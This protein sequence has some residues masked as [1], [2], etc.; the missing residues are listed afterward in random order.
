[1]TEILCVTHKYPPHIGGMERQSYELIK[2]LEKYYTV[3]KIA[4]EDN[5]NKL[6]WFQS[7]KSKI[8]QKLKEHPGIKLIHLNDGS[9]GAACLWL[10]KYTHVPVL[11]TCHGLDITFPLDLYQHKIISRLTAYD[12]AI[13]VSDSTRQECL[14]RGFREESTFTVRNGVDH[15]IADRAFDARI[16]DKLKEKQGV[17]VAGKNVLVT[18]GRSVKR[19]GFSWF[20]KNVMPLL[21]EN[22]VFLMIGS[23]KQEMPVAEKVLSSLSSTMHNKIQL[24]LGVES[25]SQDILEQLALHPN[26]HHL[27]NVPYTDLLDLTAMSDLFVMPNI[28]V[29]GDIEG[30]GLVALEA[31]MCGTFVLASELKGITDAVI[32]GHNGY[33][34]PSGKAQAWADKII[35]LFNDKPRLRQLSQQGREYTRTHYSWEIMAEGYRE[36]FDR[37]M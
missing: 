12:G 31:S 1:M 37:F 14:D 29:P 10:Q 17:D 4:Y 16:V 6:L 30:F 27:G 36:V 13:C 34:L 32:D 22:V 15:S 18:I 21:P 5:E 2:G 3:H 9:M 35:E 24:M 8:Q 28:V 7:L 26:V 20:I 33:L 25:D 19:K 11:V 23:L